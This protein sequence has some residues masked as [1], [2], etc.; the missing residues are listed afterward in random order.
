MQYIDARMARN[1]SCYIQRA[2][3][4]LSICSLSFG[5]VPETRV[6]HSDW[7]SNASCQISILNRDF[8]D[9]RIGCIRVHYTE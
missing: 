8:L 3:Y 7:T 2:K 1:E 9:E 4:A 6:Y 5:Q